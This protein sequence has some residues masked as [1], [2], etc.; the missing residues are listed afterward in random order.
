VAGGKAEGV[1]VSPAPAIVIEY[2]RDAV[3][4]VPSRTPMVTGNVPACCGNPVTLPSEIKDTPGG[5]A[6]ERIE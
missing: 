6:P 1:I 4:A 2:S 5:R 3:L